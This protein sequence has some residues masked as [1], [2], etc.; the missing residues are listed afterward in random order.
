MSRLSVRAAGDSH[1]GN[2]REHNED[3]IILDAKYGLYAVFDGMGGANAG[4]VASSKARDVVHEYVRARRAQLAPRPLLEAAINA[5]SAAVHGEA[6]RRRDR[7]GMGTT[8]VACLIEGRRATIAH[9]G[10]SRGYLRRDGRLHRLTQDHTVV[11]EL[12]ARGALAPEEADRHAYKNVL[13]RNLGA[14]ATAQIDVAEVDL[15]PGDRLLLCSDG[16]YGYAAGDAIHHVTAS[17]DAADEVVRDL[18][19]AALRGGGGD[20]VTAIVIDAGVAAQPRATVVLRTTGAGTW[21]SR[22]DRFLA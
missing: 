21:W 6:Q 5:A 15:Q 8:V 9:V 14:K 1:R 18:I 3:A 19:E 16:L 10:D 17:T 2:V 13:S 11:A 12:I 20:N 22:R 7:H 4:D